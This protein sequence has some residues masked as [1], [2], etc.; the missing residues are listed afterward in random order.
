M[1]LI[2]SHGPWSIAIA[3][4]T[5]SCPDFQTHYTLNEDNEVDTTYRWDWKG[6]TLAGMNK[7]TFSFTKMGVHRSITWS[8][9]RDRNAWYNAAQASSDA[10]MGYVQIELNA[11]YFWESDLTAGRAMENW[12]GLI[13]ANATDA[14]S[15]GNCSV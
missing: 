1:T 4:P 2:L 15:E 7:C 5:D 12:H 11:K 14:A 10:D 6:Q 3:K 8:T 13:M 9:S